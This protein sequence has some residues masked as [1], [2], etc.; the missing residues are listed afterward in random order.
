LCLGVYPLRVEVVEVL[1][2]VRHAPEAIVLSD[3][4]VRGEE[5]ALDIVPV[6]VV[7]LTLRPWNLA[8]AG[9]VVEVKKFD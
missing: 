7:K 3:E 1:L 4:L 8:N 5:D 2:F 6:N 9:C